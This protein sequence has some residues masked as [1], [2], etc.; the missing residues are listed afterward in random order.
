MK[1]AIVALMSFVIIAPAQAGWQDTTWGQSPKEVMVASAGK[2]T[3]P[4][5]VDRI[6]GAKLQRG[7]L[8]AATEIKVAG[9]TGYVR[10]FFEQKKLSL[11]RIIFAMVK[12]DTIMGAMVKK[13]G[14]PLET[15]RLGSNSTCGQANYRWKDPQAGND[16]VLSASCGS[17]VTI[18]YTPLESGGDGL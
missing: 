1:L 16:I 7:E 17:L 13:Y 10:L 11:V 5:E 4:T 15:D 3:A 12:P 9:N 6:S 8:L 18:E 14:A 2:I